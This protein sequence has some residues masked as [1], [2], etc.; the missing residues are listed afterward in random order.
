MNSLAVNS[1]YCWTK[2]VY[3]IFISVMCK[4]YGGAAGQPGNP[5]KKGGDAQLPGGKAGDALLYTK[6]LSGY[7][8]L[9]QHPGDAGHP[10]AHGHGGAGG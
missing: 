9:V 6:K 4:G 5:G 8:T 1:F 7:V 10:V 3:R 2:H